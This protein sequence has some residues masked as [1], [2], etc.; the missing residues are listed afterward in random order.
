MSI[1]NGLKMPEGPEVK[2]N[3]MALAEAVSGKTVE[4]IEILSG[5]YSRSPILGLS[6]Y[7]P[8]LPDRIIGAGA[9]G[10]FIYVLCSSGWNF[11]S[12]LGMTGIWSKNKTKHTRI[13]INFK[14]S[15]RQV[16]FNDIRNFGT[17]KIVYGKKSLVQK[18]KK[19]GPDLL[20]ENTDIIELVKNLRVKNE[21]NICKALMNQSLIAGIG[22][23]IKSEALWKTKISPLK[24]IKELEDYEL[25]EL[26]DAAKQIMISSYDS[27]GASFM[28]HADFD[29]KEGDYATGFLCYGRKID[30]L[31]NKVT[32]TKTPDGRNTHWSPRRQ[33]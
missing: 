26:I 16:Y 3:A 20:S 24:K 7:T 19:L 5:R 4:S 17:F 10:K 2:R 1:K 14:N 27:G 33:R 30:A 9:H 8:V 29:G 25:V 13:A 21:W 22:N 11:W 18:I 32:K 28:T 6:E 12:T 15:D 23:Y 31:G